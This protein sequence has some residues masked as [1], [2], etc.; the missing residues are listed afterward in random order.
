MLSCCWIPPITMLWLALSEGNWH[1]F[2]GI[3]WFAICIRPFS[4]KPLIFWSAAIR[5][6]CRKVVHRKKWDYHHSFTLDKTQ[7]K[8][9]NYF[10]RTLEGKREAFEPQSNSIFCLCPSLLYQAQSS[11]GLFL[12]HR[13]SSRWYPNVF[14]WLT[15]LKKS[16]IYKRM[17][18]YTWDPNDR[19]ADTLFSVWE[20]LYRKQVKWCS[21]DTRIHLVFL[22]YMQNFR[23]FTFCKILAERGPS[24]AFC[25]GR[26]P[27]T[28][29]QRHV[30][31]LDI[32]KSVSSLIS[33][34]SFY[35]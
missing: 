17:F 26:L 23:I 3:D 22:F 28:H 33:W 29:I 16:L 15:S 11:A 20:L 12:L 6:G 27:S 24:R 25:K 19:V 14:R 21:I 10:S 2:D 9:E 31:D 32:S 7:P 8:C 13:F 4:S 30:S 5:G 34:L 1:R 35:F 18:I